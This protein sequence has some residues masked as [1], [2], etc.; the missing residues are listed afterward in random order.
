MSSVI[1][2]PCATQVFIPLYDLLKRSGKLGAKLDF[3]I[4]SALDEPT[5]KRTT[6][7]SAL[8]S[9]VPSRVKV[10]IAKNAIARFSQK[11]GH[12]LEYTLAFTQ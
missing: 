10:A 6:L 7:A 2:A 4:R 1:H 5:G 11:I 12:S 9:V 3:D 8:K